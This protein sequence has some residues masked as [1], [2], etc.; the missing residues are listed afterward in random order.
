MTRHD[1]S[2]D[3]AVIG[4]VSTVGIPRE[5]SGFRVA[6]LSSAGDTVFSRRFL[7][8]GVRLERRE[9]DSAI[10]ATIERLRG[11]GWP[12]QLSRAF[13]EAAPRRIPR[14]RQPYRLFTV[15]MDHSMWI[16]LRPENGTSAWL[17]LDSTG[18]EIGR[19]VL[20]DRMTLVEYG[21]SRAWVLEADEDGVQSVLRL[22]ISG[23]RN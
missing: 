9:A 21:G 4:F 15:A 8:P 2:A 20:P 3:G 1:V 12:S 23:G 19:L 14:Y 7:V 18:A 17:G 22:S 13:E 16:Q 10:A 5:E 11:R 6:L